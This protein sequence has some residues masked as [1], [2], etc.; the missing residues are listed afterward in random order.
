M[1]LVFK[2]PKP[3][4]VGIMEIAKVQPFDDVGI[5]RLVM[6]KWQDQLG[7]ASGDRLGRGSNSPMMSHKARTFKKPP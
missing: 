7:H 4:P 2:P 5:V 1:N 3:D 6:G